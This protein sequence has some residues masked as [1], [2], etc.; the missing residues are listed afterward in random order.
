MILSDV[1]VEDEDVHIYV[2][3]NIMYFRLLLL[4]HSHGVTNM[5]I[6][7]KLVDF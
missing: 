5:I 4:L 3:T 6:T 2:Q 7:L 1:P